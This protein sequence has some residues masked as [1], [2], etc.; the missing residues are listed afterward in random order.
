MFRGQGFK[1]YFGATGPDSRVNI[2]GIT[3]R[4]SDK[5]KVGRSAIFKQ[6]LD[7]FGHIRITWVIISRI[8]FDAFIL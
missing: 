5:D 3:G 1:V 8:K 6:F 2:P 7:V 4:C